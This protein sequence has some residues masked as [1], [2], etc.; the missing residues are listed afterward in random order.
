[1]PPAFARRPRPRRCSV[2]SELQS[3]RIFHPLAA[4]DRTHAARVAPRYGF[5]HPAQ[6]N[7]VRAGGCAIAGWMAL[8]SFVLFGC[9][10]DDVP[11]AVSDAGED[12]SADAGDGGCAVTACTDPST[13]VCGSDGVCVECGASVDCLDVA[14]P[15]CMR[16]TCSACLGDVQCAMNLD[17]PVC[18][19][20]GRCVECE[21][22]A[23]CPVEAPLCG[24]SGRCVE[25]VTSSDCSG[26]APACSTAGQCVSCTEVTDCTRDQFA[27][28]IRGIICESAL[29]QRGSSLTD[30]G[31]LEAFV[32]AGDVDGFPG[33]SFLDAAIRNGTLQVDAATIAACRASMLDLSAESACATAMRPTLDDTAPCSLDA[34]CRSGRCA[35]AD[36]ACGGE[37]A[38]PLVPGG[39]CLRDGDCAVGSVC[40]SRY[41]R[42][43]VDV[44]GSCAGAVCLDGLYCN[45][46]SVC[47]S[48]GTVGATCR[49]GADGDC[50][51]GLYCDSGH[52][53]T[54]PGEGAPCL[55]DWRSPRCGADLQCAGTTCAV[56]LGIGATCTTSEECVPGAG[57]AATTC[58]Q[59]VG[60]GARCSIDVL[61]PRGMACT[62]ARCRPLPDIGA[63]C[64]DSTGCLR[65]RCLSGTCA[66]APLFTPCMAGAYW[67][68]TLDPCGA[69]SSCR[70]TA[71]GWQ[72]TPE[73]T[74][75]GLCSGTSALPCRSPDTYCDGTTCRAICMPI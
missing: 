37:C 6:V 9:G 26:S 22:A 55:A 24:A 25:C 18:A 23:E 43:F 32:C 11:A 15:I 39:I 75:G 58:K 40:V 28:E 12:S 21:I 60:S 33:L 50:L 70:D 46:S 66:D 53:A 16:G 30:D 73:A 1:M 17:L 10:G 29:G 27:D 74:L 19:A 48:R 63:P 42:A 14:K 35:A 4:C 72:C 7:T 65:G 64:S 38:A 36:R 45:A 54:R 3:C 5:S 51:A 68:D 59:I 13:P 61:C 47:A 8:T 34:E 20:D 57:C 2:G 52:C 67:F 69:S 71:S 62:D 41:C 31:S 49:S 56:P 44:G